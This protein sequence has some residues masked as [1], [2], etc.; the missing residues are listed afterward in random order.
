MTSDSCFELGL[1]TRPHGLKGEVQVHL[2]VDFPEDYQDLESV[3]VEI[4][5]QLVPFFISSLHLTKDQKAIVQ[6]D[7][8]DSFEAAEKIKGVKLFLPLDF[9]PELEA[10]Q[11]YFHQVVGYKVIDKSLGELGEVITF[12]DNSAQTIMLM[13]YQEKEVLIPIVEGVFVK[14]DHKNKTFHVDLPEGLLDIYLNED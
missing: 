2:D 3:F 1:I 4:N 10:D 13:D 11:F 6:F 14:A 8:I 7:D 5:N 12:N 9:L